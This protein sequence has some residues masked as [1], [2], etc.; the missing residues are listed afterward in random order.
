MCNPP[1]LGTGEDLPPVVAD[2]EPAV[3]LWSG[4]TGS[5]AV[6]QVIDGAAA[7]LR[8]GGA[9][10]LEAA[11][12]RA[13]HTAATASRAGFQRVRVERDLAG[14]ERVVIGHLP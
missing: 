8:P 14:L 9:L 7:W 5:E 10:V 3:A 2:W 11:S 13:Q 1:Y 4:P 12:H 6:E